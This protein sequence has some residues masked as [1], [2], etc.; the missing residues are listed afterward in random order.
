[1][2][3]FFLGTSGH[4]LGFTHDEIIDIENDRTTEVLF[5]NLHTK[6]LN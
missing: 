4:K 5:D 6:V 3:F 1:M 2:I